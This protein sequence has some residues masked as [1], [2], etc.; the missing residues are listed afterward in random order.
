[1]ANP[2]LDRSEIASILPHRDPFLFVDAVREIEPGKHIV[3]E[4]VVAEDQRFLRRDDPS[5]AYL[6]PTILAEAMAQVG[7]ILV[8]Y[9]EEHRGR[10]IYFRAIE[11]AE[12]L[13]RIDAGAT[14]VIEATVRKLR[15]RFGTLDVSAKVN[16]ELAAK[17]VMSF[18]LG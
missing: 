1:M 9:P 2:V 5:G 3:G 4:L 10:T 6:P 8:L 7:A 11:E 17:A 15:S 13:K 18:A 12:F 14:V 16:G